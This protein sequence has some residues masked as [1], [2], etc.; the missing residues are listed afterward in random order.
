MQPQI[1][2]IP[3]CNEDQFYMHQESDKEKEMEH[4]I[5]SSSTGSLSMTLSSISSLSSSLCNS[6]VRPY[7]T[8]Q[9]AFPIDASTPV[10]TRIRDLTVPGDPWYDIPAGLQTHQ[11]DQENSEVVH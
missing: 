3:D 8:E 9:Q 5:D 2:M 6:E 10:Q 1:Q 7:M 11:E 4:G